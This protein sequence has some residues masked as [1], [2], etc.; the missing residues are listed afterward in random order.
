MC[1]HRTSVPSASAARRGVASRCRADGPRGS[2]LAN[3]TAQAPWPGPPARRADQPAWAAWS[4]RSVRSA[5]SA[6]P[7]G[8]SA[9]S[10]CPS[11]SARLGLL[12]SVCLLSGPCSSRVHG[13]ISVA[14]R[15]S[16]PLPLPLP[17]SLPRACACPLAR[18]TNPPLPAGTPRPRYDVRLPGP[19]AVADRVRTTH[20]RT[21][22]HGRLSRTRDT[23]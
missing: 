16:L 22:G 4:A 17:P 9:W 2:W 5:W 3:P 15:S 7:A 13:A 20:S 1:A 14:S 12:D 18:A 19:G 8:C 23:N 6:R 21:S 11:Q 10:A